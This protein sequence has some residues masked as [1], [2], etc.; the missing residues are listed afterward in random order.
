MGRG[1]GGYIGRGNR[2]VLTNRGLCDG[3]DMDKYGL[4]WTL[5]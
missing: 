4:K 5:I 3:F 2:C 1:A